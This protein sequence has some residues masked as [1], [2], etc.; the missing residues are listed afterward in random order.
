MVKKGEITVESVSKAYQ[1]REGE[2]SALVDVDFQAEG[3][4]LVVPIG[5]SGCGKGTLLHCIGGFIEPKSGRIWLDDLEIK[6]PSPDRGIV[7]QREPFFC[8]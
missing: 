7:F 1:I 2:V 3:G 6:R 4:E 5:P 8:G